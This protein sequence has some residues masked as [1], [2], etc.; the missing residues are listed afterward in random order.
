M[1]F[2][3]SLATWC[4]FSLCPFFL[5]PFFPVPFFPVPFFRCH[6]FRLPYAP[7]PYIDI[8]RPRCQ[9]LDRPTIG[10]SNGGSAGVGVGTSLMTPM[11]STHESVP[12][13]QTQCGQ[14]I[15]YAY[16]ADYWIY[17]LVLMAADGRS[18]WIETRKSELQENLYSVKML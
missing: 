12:A 10:W 11:K 7:R 16:R 8:Y 3:P 18:I 1:P 5:V 13:I 15:A 17:S 2:F 4:H 6:F 14:V 9:N